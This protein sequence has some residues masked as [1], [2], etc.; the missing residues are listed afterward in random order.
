MKTEVVLHKKFVSGLYESLLQDT[1]DRGMTITAVELPSI[2]GSLAFCGRQS[3]ALALYESKLNKISLQQKII[4]RFFIGVGWVRQSQFKKAF[5]AFRNNQIEGRK[6]EVDEI[7][8]FISQGIAFYLF[9]HGNY[10]RAL[11]FAKQAQNTAISSQDLFAR[12]LASDLIGHCQVAI[13][14]LIEGFENLRKASNLAKNANNHGL[15]HA[16]ELALVLYEAQYG[17]HSLEIIEKL[18]QLSQSAEYQ[19]SYSYSD[20]NLE[21]A[22]QYSLRGKYDDALTAIDLTTKFVL[23]AKNRRQEIVLYLRK[24]EVHYQRAEFLNALMFLQSA[25]KSLVTEVD[26]AFELQILGLEMKCLKSSANTLI[27]ETKKNEILLLSKK[28]SNHIHV[29]IL[30]RS[31]DLQ[32]SE[33]QPNRTS[34]DKLGLFID[35]VYKKNIDSSVILRSGYLS[36]FYEYFGLPRGQEIVFISNKKNQLLFMSK[37]GIYKSESAPTDLTLKVFFALSDQKEMTRQQFF[38]SVWGLRYHRQRHDSLIYTTMSL[39]RKNM[40]EF[41]SWIQTTDLGYQLRAKVIFEENP[42]ESAR[43][44]PLENS[45]SVADQVP[46]PSISAAISVAISATIKEADGGSIQAIIKRYSGY[47]LNFRQIKIIKYLQS[48]DFIT[49]K[50][51]MDANQIT[52]ISANRDLADLFRK[53]I[54]LRLGKARATKYVLPSSL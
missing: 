26:R 31:F 10:H 16:I 44:K 48:H 32:S 14:Y 3:E 36:F 2:V 33:I 53:K 51:H 9:Y 1:F 4:C 15:S 6:S 52:E 8:F 7:R 18:K 27:Y 34:E 25:R 20:L 29:N 40:G 24:A 17:Y 30:K 47:S 54:I 38:E 45:E 21:L 5:R 13:G 23:V 28:Y 22:R 12:I 11:R 50:M 49:T 39:I 35:S 41:S 37:H 19:D 46:S 43:L 42:Q